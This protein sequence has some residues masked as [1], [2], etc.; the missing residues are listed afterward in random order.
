MYS[1]EYGETNVIFLFL[2]Y[3]KGNI[4]RQK[5]LNS[6]IKLY[7]LVCNDTYLWSNGQNYTCSIYQFCVPNNGWWWCPNGTST[8]G[9]IWTGGAYY[10]YPELNCCGCGK[11]NLVDME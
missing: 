7:Y 1:L 6:R 3:L 8:P 9:T 5:R 11:G 4:V 10:K 2:G